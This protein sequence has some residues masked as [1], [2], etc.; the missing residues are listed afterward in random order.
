LLTIYLYVLFYLSI[1][2]IIYTDTAPSQHPNKKISVSIRDR[3]LVTIYN[4]HGF[5]VI[6][7]ISHGITIL[8]FALKKG[9]EI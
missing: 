4:G 6:I 5:G 1:F 7:F 8:I 9:A 3:R 2:P